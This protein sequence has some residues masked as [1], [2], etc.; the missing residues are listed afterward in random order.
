MSTLLDTLENNRVFFGH[1]RKNPPLDP[2]I[3]KSQLK[4]FLNLSLDRCMQAVDARSGSIFLFDYDKKELVLGIAHNGKKIGFEGIKT[5]LGE[6][7]IGKVAL[8]RK[9][10]LIKDLDQ[11]PSLRLSPRF[12]YT[13]K[14]FLSVPL[15]FSGDLMGVLSLTDKT[16]GKAFDNND[17]ST[18][19]SICKQLGLAIFSL[20]EYLK[21]Q[22]SLNEELSKVLNELKLSSERHKKF[23]SLG[24]FAG[25]LVHEINNPL[26][27]VIRFV[28]LSLNN[29]SE[30]DINREYLLD[31]KKGLNRI[32][33]F[34]R[35]LLNFTW[36]LSSRGSDMSIRQS[37]DES[38]LH[39][40]DKLKDN[41]VS[42]E[43]SVPENLPRIPD[44][45]L[46][47]VFNN[48]I[49]NAIEAMRE[50]GGKLSVFVFSG[51][52]FIEVLVSDTGKGVPG[53][54]K[55]K[56][57]DPFFTTKGMGE[58]S[59]LGLA[60]SYEIVERYRGSI[61]VES[62]EGR[63][64]IFRIRLPLHEKSYIVGGAGQ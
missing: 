3:L 7:V 6:R 4:D 12:D 36:S 28:N 49:K 26:D 16:D 33:T 19:L 60:I 55:N 24:K 31:A 42:V 8:E 51:N 34:V 32:A 10:L 54:I 1:N 39:L 17:L 21:K 46:K 59:G 22:N 53:D 9:A 43:T 30:D 48:L 29:M 2:Q 44:Y 35:S 18:V 5:R 11:E 62:E 64:S 52:D 20:T 15:E 58:G 25:G 38:L 14:S 56:I 37:I 47:I 23:T 57:F 63:G 61:T 40:S 41:N 50:N 13:S 27:G 45:G